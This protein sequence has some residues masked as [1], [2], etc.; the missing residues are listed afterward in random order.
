VNEDE[1]RRE[2]DLEQTDRLLS[3]TRAVRRRL[4]LQRPVDADVVLDCLRIAAQAPSGGNAQ[5]WRWLLVEDADTRRA[6][7]DHYAAAY[8]RYI[9]PRREAVDPGDV[10][11][12]RILAS[13]D[14]LAEHLADVPLHVIPCV[15]DR[16][17]PGATNEQMAGFYGSVIPAIWSFQL[18]LRSRGLGSAYT[19]LHLVHE[20]EVAGLLGIP[21]TVTQVALLPVAHYTG[22]RFQPA[23]R[24]PVEEIT[25][26]DR[27]K[28]RRVR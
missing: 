5:R 11:T 19:T 7:A 10:A 12:E 1:N 15:L 26:H 4:D 17:P 24:R 13:S 21:P 18:A 8:A 14:H 6:L 20:A 9:A 22:T 2:F 28:Q 3:T 16:L 27:W 25:Y 23:P